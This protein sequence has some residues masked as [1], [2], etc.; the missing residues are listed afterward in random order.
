MTSRE[1]D[2]IFFARL[3]R[4][5]K[6]GA[7]FNPY[8]RYKEFGQNM[9]KR[10][11]ERRLNALQE[12]GW[13]YWVGD[14]LQLISIDKL[15]VIQCGKEEKTKYFY[16]PN[17]KRL[18][19]DCLRVVLLKLSERGQKAESSKHTEIKSPKTVFKKCGDGDL[20]E[21]VCDLRKDVNMG[22]RTFR[23]IIGKESHVTA[24]RTYL[25]ASGKNLIHLTRRYILNPNAKHSKII[26]GVKMEKLSFEFETRFDMKL[27]HRKILSQCS[28]EERVVRMYCNDC[29]DE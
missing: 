13:A 24:W 12:L 9:S 25:R 5:H 2:L 23:N 28:L 11:Y 20:I 4:H 7:I 16:L 29:Y 15:P 26:N 1:R 27:R 21:T 19:F 18:D 17:D 14:T 22:T 8:E 10:T 6:S 3:K